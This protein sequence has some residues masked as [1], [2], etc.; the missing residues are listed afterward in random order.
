[1]KTRKEIREENRAARKALRGL[2]REERLE[3]R[4]NLRN[5]E[6]LARNE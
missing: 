6:K 2:P 3:A 5:K 1:M 4:K